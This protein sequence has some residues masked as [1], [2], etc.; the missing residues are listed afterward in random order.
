MLSFFCFRTVVLSTL[1]FMVSTTA[2]TQ[3]SH[4]GC[5]QHKHQFHWKRAGSNLAK[6]STA[7][8]S[9]SINLIKHTVLLD[10]SNFS[11]QKK[12]TR[13]TIAFESL[14]D[15]IEF[16][17][18][19]LKGQIVDSVTHT[20]GQI[21]YLYSNEILE[22]EL[23]EVLYAGM[24]DQITVHYSGS[25]VTDPSGFGGFYFSSII[26][27]NIG[28]AFT[29][30]PPSYGRA[31]IPCFDNFVE[32]SEYEFQVL[33]T[34]GRSA[35]CNGSLQ[36]IDTLNGDTILTTWVM[37]QEISSYL[38]SVAV[39]DYEQTI[40]QFE[41]ISGDTIPVYLV[42]YENNL[43]SLEN[44]FSNLETVFHAFEDWF[45]P[46]RWPRIG[47]NLTPVG[48][49]EHSTNISYPPTLLGSSAA[50]PVMAHELAHEWFGNLVTCDHPS[51]MWLNEGWAE[52]L[53]ILAYEAISG[54]EEYASRMRTNHK[55][56]L[57]KAH[58]LDGG[59]LTMNAI[60]PDMTYGEHVYNKGACMAH[61]LRG[62]LGD[63]LFFE[64]MK[65]YLNTFEFGNTNSEDLKDFLNTHPQIDV[66]DFFNDW[67]FQPG[68]SQFSVDEMTTEPAE[69]GYFVNLEIRQ[70]LR[71]ANEYYQNVPITLSL[72]DENWNVFETQITAGGPLTSTV[73]TAP[74][75]PVYA[76]LNRDEKLTYA[77]TAGEESITDEGFHLFN[78]ALA[79]VIVNEITDTANLRVEHNWAGPGGNVDDN[80]YIISPDR[81]W[82]IGGIINEDFT[83]DVRFDFDGRN[84]A[85]GFI[86]VELFDLAGENFI[87]E[88]LALLYRSH[89]NE[90]W[91]VWEDYTT[92]TL[93]EN[94]NGYARLTAHN[95]TL[96]E[97]TF[98]YPNP[99]VSAPHN[100]ATI[101]SVYPNP[102][103]E[104]VVIDLGNSFLPQSEIEIFNLDGKLVLKQI[105]T[106]P[107]HK[108]NVASLAKGTYL[109]RVHYKGKMIEQEQIVLH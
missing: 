61:S 57:H 98:G 78:H 80:A 29:D 84:T 18:L 40:W 81:Y 35:Y 4:Y 101:M 27:Y 103:R 88:D 52:F 65:E 41:S 66:T 53:S 23:P 72:M 64:A 90:P 89:P 10:F 9:D 69:N 60:P 95:I 67:I 43:S 108:I 96:G 58:F 25:D 8:I 3:E 26:A 87:E 17:P 1:F 28:V 56:M 19:D 107:L 30:W 102:A 49:M 39:S 63:E 20:S 47:F 31:W 106:G 74:F 24:A 62:Y 12:Y 22:V 48:A 13:C 91:E 68:W 109:L 100:S 16:L 5:K 86:D 85:N 79:T 59:F 75:I 2:F 76:T 15:S 97:Y 46:Y 36:S 7:S 37:N 54:P 38:A 32:K 33:T 71:A 83:A 93:G 14:V 42:G 104:S 99:D 70:R 21:N 44:N 94:D 77:V 92:L 73:V 6:S 50:E 45:G 105:M 34:G 82:R 51:D 55:N 11:D